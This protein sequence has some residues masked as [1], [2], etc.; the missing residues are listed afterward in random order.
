MKD[1]KLDDHPKILSGFKYPE[2]YFDSLSA[3]INQKISIEDNKVIPLNS[4]KKIWFYAVAAILI[5]GLGMTTFYVISIKPTVSNEIAI[6]NYFASQPAITE[7][8]LL[9]LLEKEDIAE[10]EIDYNF[11]DKIVEDLLST[12]ANLEQY[13][14]N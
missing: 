1:F 6:E 11:D 8:L 4:R 5:V 13:I 3:S 12:N 14:I 7:D 9:E 2:G 10:I